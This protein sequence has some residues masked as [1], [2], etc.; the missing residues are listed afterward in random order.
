MVVFC[1]CSKTHNTSECWSG[2]QKKCT[3]EEAMSFCFVSDSKCYSICSCLSVML[4]SQNCYR[5]N[6]C[7]LFCLCLCLKKPRISKSNVQLRYG[8]FLIF[9]YP[10]IGPDL[11]CPRYSTLKGGLLKM[12]RRAGPCSAPLW[13]YQ[14][15]WMYVS[16]RYRQDLYDLS[17]LLSCSIFGIIDS[18]E[19][20]TYIS[21]NVSRLSW[22]GCVLFLPKRALRSNIMSRS[23]WEPQIVRCSRHVFCSASASASASKSWEYQ[24]SLWTTSCP[25][26]FLCSKSWEY[27]KLLQARLW[28]RSGLRRSLY[29]PN[30][31]CA[32]HVYSQNLCNAHMWFA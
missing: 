21:K 18:L 19:I 31:F 16:K 24:K 1:F 17:L 6:P 30:M 15:L 4:L 9:E 13:I 8:V 26:F 29:P 22:R 14:W 3:T 12:S 20:W 32:K 10:W 7:P 25:L 11:F 5:A 28:S 27:S 23:S 2:S